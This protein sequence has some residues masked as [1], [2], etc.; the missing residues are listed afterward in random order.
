MVPLSLGLNYSNYYNKTTLRTFLGQ[1]V[2]FRGNFKNS[3]FQVDKLDRAQKKHLPKDLSKNQT[4][5]SIFKDDRK[6]AQ[7]PKVL[8]FRVFCA[9]VLSDR[10]SKV[11]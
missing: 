3:L 5:K 7:E 2:K 6:T 11:F 8:G 1:N 10:D 9:I 4:S